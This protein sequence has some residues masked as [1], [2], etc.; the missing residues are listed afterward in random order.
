MGLGSY[1]GALHRWESEGQD[2]GP[3]SENAIA[4]IL[5]RLLRNNSVKRGDLG[6]FGGFGL[7]DRRF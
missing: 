6:L 4:G 7:F 1:R 5:A 2:S 3:P